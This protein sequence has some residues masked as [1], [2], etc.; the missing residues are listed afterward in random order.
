MNQHIIK[1]VVRGNHNDDLPIIRIEKQ[2]VQRSLTLVSPYRTAPFGMTTN[3]EIYPNSQLQFNR[4]NPHKL[5]FEVM[6]RTKN[7]YHVD[8]NEANSNKPVIHSN[9]HQNDPVQV[10]TWDVK[11]VKKIDPSFPID[12]NHEIVKHLTP[13]QIATNI[14]NFLKMHSIE[15]VYDNDEA[16]AYAKTITECKFRIYLFRHDEK[17]VLVEVQRRSG[18]CAKFHNIANKILSASKG[19]EYRQECAI[20]IDNHTSLC[21]EPDCW[22]ICDENH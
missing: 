13:S 4:D 22:D 15:A 17:D 20:T 9:Y 7:S 8:S 5:K 11:N 1:H 6:N 18:C 12:K 19:C 14:Y 10:G 2:P 16:I 21:G 3:R